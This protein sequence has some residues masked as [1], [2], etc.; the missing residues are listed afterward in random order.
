MLLTFNKST[1]ET[2]CRRPVG[3]EP[4]PPQATWWTPTSASFTARQQDDGRKQ[5][6]GNLRSISILR[7]SSI[8]AST[9][10]S[11]WRLGSRQESGGTGPVDGGPPSSL[12][13]GTP[14]DGKPAP[15]LGGRRTSADGKPSPSLGDRRP[16]DGEPSPLLVICPLGSFTGRAADR[17]VRMI[18]QDGD[19]IWRW[20][21][22]SSLP[23]IPEPRKDYFLM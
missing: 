21:A 11:C 6:M 3:G 19:P 7:K 17:L 18:S 15:S 1:L 20:A 4:P 13:D 14:A 8:F 16:A 23:I 10:V 2:S 12:G 22:F 5:C 9:E